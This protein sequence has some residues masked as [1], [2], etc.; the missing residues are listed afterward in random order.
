MRCKVFTAM[1]IKVMVLQKVMSCRD[2]VCGISSHKIDS[3]P[4]YIQIFVL[5]LLFFIFSYVEYLVS[6]FSMTLRPS[7]RVMTYK[8]F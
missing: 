7:S 4:P 8:V 1:E 3:N 2:V 5:V 6:P